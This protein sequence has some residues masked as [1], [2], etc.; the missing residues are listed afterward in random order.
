MGFP[1]FCFLSWVGQT[2]DTLDFDKFWK[3]TVNLF[4]LFQEFFR[5]NQYNQFL[6][7]KENLPKK[8]RK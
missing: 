1:E 5:L 4:D 8:K 6:K 2:N 3:N 7:Q